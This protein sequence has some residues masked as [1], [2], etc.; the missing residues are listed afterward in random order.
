MLVKIMKY[1]SIKNLI[2]YRFVYKAWYQIIGSNTSI[3]STISNTS[4]N[5][6]YLLCSHNDYYTLK[7]KEETI[8]RKL[9]NYKPKLFGLRK[10]Y[11]KVR[12]FGCCNGLLCVADRGLY[13]SSSIYLF[14][15]IIRKNKKIPL[16]NC[17]HVED[18]NLCFRYYDDDDYKV[19][20]IT[21][22]DGDYRV[23]VYSLSTDSWKTIICHSDYSTFD[24]KE[25]N[26]SKYVCGV[27]YFLK[28]KGRIVYFDF[29]DK[30]IRE[31]E[32]SGNV[33]SFLN[34]SIYVEAYG[35]SLTLV[36]CSDFNDN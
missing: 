13:T 28:Y 8:N 21:P 17:G 11:D 5:R 24:C 33:D 20:K 6:M 15:P 19:I 34:Y 36:V 9:Y 27:A 7:R 32:L 1:L 2:Q 23:D 35:E 30:T 26:L 12:V 25:N 16:N 31:V 4:N 10:R 29:R 14:N 3:K 22:F 18:A